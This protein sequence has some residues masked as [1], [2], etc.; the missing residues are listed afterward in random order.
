MILSRS[1]HWDREEELKGLIGLE[2]IAHDDGNAAKTP[3]RSVSVD[4]RAASNEEQNDAATANSINADTT[5]IVQE[6]MRKHDLRRCSH[7]FFE[8]FLDGAA[9]VMYT[10]FLGLIVDEFIIWGSSEVK[11]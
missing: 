10:S 8:H 1:D 4:K 11:E 6:N 5:M 7:R 9:G 2:I 3:R